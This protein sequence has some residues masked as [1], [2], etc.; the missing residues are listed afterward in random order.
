MRSLLFL[1]LTLSTFACA[2][3][4]NKQYE[5]YKNKSNYTSGYIIDEGGQKVYGLVRDMHDGY[6]GEFVDFVFKDGVKK[7]LS[8][9][10]IK[11]YGFSIY[12]YVAT[13]EG[14]LEVITRGKKVTL[15]KETRI[16]AQS[17]TSAVRDNRLTPILESSNYYIQHTDSTDLKKVTALNFQKVSTSFFFDCIYLKHTIETGEHRFR[18]LKKVVSIYN[19]DCK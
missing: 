19:N 18:D 1:A 4:E 14:F 5:K 11:G 8:P 16:S 10:E 2:A 9:K 6:R 7:S 17:P 13:E 12:E 15:F 3:Q